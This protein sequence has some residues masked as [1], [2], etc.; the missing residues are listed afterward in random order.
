MTGYVFLAVST[1]SRVKIAVGVGKHTLALT[2][3]ILP[4]TLVLPLFVVV[5]F[6]DG[7]VA[8]GLPLAV[9]FF[10]RCKVKVS[11]A[12]FSDCI[13]KVTF[14]ADFVFK[15]CSSKP[16]QSNQYGS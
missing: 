13:K 10:G 7:V 2:T 4:I 16:Q 14:V 5:H 3:T 1:P 11:A 8:V 9:V 15:G 6:S 12:A